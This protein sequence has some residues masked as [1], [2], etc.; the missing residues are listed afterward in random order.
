MAE[1]KHLRQAAATVAAPA[2]RRRRSRPVL[3]LPLLAV[4]C[5]GA[6]AAD[7]QQGAE[8][9]VVVFKHGF[10]ASKVKALCTQQAAG[11]GSS[12]RLHGL[13]RRR[14]SAVL[15]G[16]A[17]E[18]LFIGVVHRPGVTTSASPHL[19]FCS[20]QRDVHLHTYRPLTALPCLAAGTLARPDLEALQEA[21]PG[22]I[23]YIERD[24]SFQI[25]GGPQQDWLNSDVVPAAARKQR[26]RQ[27][28]GE[29]R[30]WQRRAAAG[31]R[32]KLPEQQDASWTLDRIDQQALPLDRLYHY[33]TAGSGVNV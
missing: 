30:R 27:L 6:A 16:F 17:G 13:C 7:G 24:S 20:G 22:S 32:R 19:F 18:M 4:L 9:Y 12:G 14:F 11:G 28:L 8:E 2:T 25:T 5:L 3:L 10:D 1:R 33:D 21:F 26:R 29:H 31:R 23:E 15:N